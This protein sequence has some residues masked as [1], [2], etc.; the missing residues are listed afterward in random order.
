MVH[1]K[2]S[3]TGE[4]TGV[5]SKQRTHNAHQIDFIVQ[6]QTVG[7]TPQVQWAGPKGT[8]PEAVTPHSERDVLTP[9]TEVSLAYWNLF[10]LFVWFAFTVRLVLVEWFSNKYDR[11]GLGLLS[12]F[13]VFN[14]HYN[15]NNLSQH[16]GTKRM[17]PYMI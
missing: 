4:Y 3:P 5:P 14:S 16:L 17:S 7:M 9:T 11:R 10:L 13:Y 12:C 6:V 8:H 15:E 1:P 2:A